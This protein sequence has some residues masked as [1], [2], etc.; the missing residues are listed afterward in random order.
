MESPFSFFGLKFVAVTLALAI[1]AFTSISLAQEAPSLSAEPPAWLEQRQ[2]AAS[3]A[4]DWLTDLDNAEFAQA[5]K[6]YTVDGD[7]AENENRLRGM[8]E[9]LGSLV[10]RTFKWAT[11]T[12]VANDD[13][14][15]RVTV[16]YETEF[17]NKTVVESLDV[18]LWPKDP[19]ILTY[20]LEQE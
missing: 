5:V 15:H 1:V 8:R 10:S 4:S 13:S 3:F 11:V 9:G 16:A 2:D 7:P 18:L 19:V 17:A 12:A 6:A 20:R 14:E